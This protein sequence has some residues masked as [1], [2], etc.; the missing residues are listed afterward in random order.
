MGIAI[1]I[2]VGVTSRQLV[3]RVRKNKIVS[4]LGRAI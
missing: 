2:L 4:G 1:E 3:C